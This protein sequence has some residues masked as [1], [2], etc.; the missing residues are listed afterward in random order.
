LERKADF[1]T[2]NYIVRQLRTLFARNLY[3]AHASAKIWM[4]ADD[5]YLEAVRVIQTPSVFR[6]MGIH[7]A[8]ARK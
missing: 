5:T 8:D 6:K 4:E 2:E 1:D 3:D 7:D